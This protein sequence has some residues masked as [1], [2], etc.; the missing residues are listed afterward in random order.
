MKALL[1]ILT[2][3][4]CM[5]ASATH[6]L[7][8]YVYHEMFY[9][10]GP[11]S[12]TDI[13]ESSE[14]KYL[15]AEAYNDLFGTVTVQLVDKMLSRLKDKKPAVYDWPYELGFQGDTVTLSINGP[16][17][18]WETI[19]HEVTATLTL[20]G[21]SAVTFKH[22]YRQETWT[23][24]DLTLPYLDLVNGPPSRGE[25]TAEQEQVEPVQA[26]SINTQ[27]PM[28]AD[29]INGTPDEGRDPLKVWLLLSGLANVGLIGLLVMK[30]KKHKA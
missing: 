18:M 22:A 15:T 4:L 7:T 13:L 17:A 14:Y 16:V 5:S 19:Q 30:R 20:N 21:F 24:A 26:D 29:P 9:E 11:W 23:I 1:T 27:D 12:R 3:A 6:W 2:M 25:P 10:Q 28:D 8:Y